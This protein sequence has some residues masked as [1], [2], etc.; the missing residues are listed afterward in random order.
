MS[1]FEEYARRFFVFEQEQNVFRTS[2]LTT[3]QQGSSEAAYGGLIFA[4]AL[5]A[6]ENTV[7]EKYKPHAMH[8]FF[9]LNGKFFNTW[10][11]RRGH[12]FLFDILAP[13]KCFQLILL[14]VHQV[15]IY[16]LEVEPDSAVHQDTMPNITSWKKL[17]TVAEAIRSLRA[18]IAEGKIKLKSSADRYVR[19]LESR[20]T[21]TN[22]DLFEVSS[23]LQILLGHTLWIILWGPM[24]HPPAGRFIR[25]LKHGVFLTIVRSCI[26]WYE[27]LN[28][29][30]SKLVSV[31]RYLVAYNSDATM[32]SS[33]YRPHIINDFHPS[34]VFSL[35]HNVWMHQHLMR[36][37]QWMLFENTSTVAG[38]GRAFTTGKLWNE[39]GVLLLSCTQEIVIEIDRV[40]LGEY[41]T[42]FCF[43]LIS[44]LILAVFVYVRTST[45]TTLHQGSSEAAYGGLIFAQAL[46]AAENTVEEK[47]K[48]HA[49]HS[50]FLLN[51]LQVEPDSAIHQDA[52]PNITSWKELKSMAEA[53][54]SLRAEIAEDR[55]MG[56]GGPSSNCRTFY[57]WMKT[58]G[59]LDGC[60]KL[61]R[62]LVAYI[63]DATMAGSASRPHLINDFNPSMVF[64]L[65]HNVW[66]HQ[67]LIR[68]DQWMLFENSSTVAGR[69]RAFTT[70][71][72]WNE[73]G[74]LLLSCTQEI[75]I[76]GRG[77]TSQI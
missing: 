66:M 17:K 20:T 7:E 47:Y 36:A 11:E 30:K 59:V 23:L 75:V 58:W 1:D 28:P 55:L 52:M 8:S 61:H 27:L 68:A 42:N 44:W 16:D 48:P 74:V 76:R 45:L 25:G 37:D 40:M 5:A 69:G 18:E 13:N 19:F 3:L 38:R 10:G 46:A 51:D 57:S 64:S 12:E 67:H 33:A 31:F 41:V 73:D 60:E 22:E 24:S 50:F 63:S 9:L 72:L 29:A 32:A 21:E 35:D 77:V 54:P 62:Y 43:N 56:I 71:K 14:I 49:M 6:A 53:I 65:D 26:G 70:G 15:F 34:M 39:D 2:T 4:Q